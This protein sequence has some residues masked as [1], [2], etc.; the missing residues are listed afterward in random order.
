MAVNHSTTANTKSVCRWF[1]VCTV[2]GLI[3]RG[4]ADV[5]MLHA[6]SSTI[7]NGKQQSAVTSVVFTCRRSPSVVS[8][9]LKKVPLPCDDG[10]AG[11]SPW[12]QLAPNASY[13][14]S[15][16]V[17]A[18]R[19]LGST[20]RLGDWRDWPRLLPV[21]RSPLEHSLQAEG[22]SVYGQFVLLLIEGCTF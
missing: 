1:V 3:L 21:G 4:L 19:R 13:I 17:F 16:S 15:V 5:E 7:I 18:D 8:V 10:S 2:L 9:V 22:W 20:T 11:F 12:A 14:H 6:D